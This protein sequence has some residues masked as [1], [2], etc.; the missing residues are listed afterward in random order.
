[1][2]VVHCSLSVDPILKTTSRCHKNQQCDCVHIEDAKLI[3]D[4]EVG[5]WKVWSNIYFYD[6]RR[7]KIHPCAK[8]IVRMRKLLELL[9]SLLELWGPFS[10]SSYP[11]DLPFTQ[12][13]LSTLFTIYPL[14]QHYPWELQHIF[15]LSSNPSTSSSADWEG[16]NGGDQQNRW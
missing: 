11:Q 5:K 2:L 16:G 9:W 4:I 12:P 10:F 7:F 13:G 15:S 1:M 8:N 6:S 3:H 14:Y